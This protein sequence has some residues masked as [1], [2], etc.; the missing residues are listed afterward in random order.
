MG[1]RGRNNI[2]ELTV[3]QKG[4]QRPAPPV[5]LTKEE[6]A[7]WREVVS[8]LSPDWF[9]PDT[10]PLLVQYCRHVN[11]A[12]QISQLVETMMTGKKPRFMGRGAARDRVLWEK[13]LFLL[14]EKEESISRVIATLATK[15]RIC[16]QSTYDKSKKKGKRSGASL[17]D[18]TALGN[19]GSE[20]EEA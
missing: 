1:Q 10:F 8:G 15:M 2:I 18:P 6:A 14:L 9:T 5:E 3:A 12:R 13:H 11:R 20:G 17:W 19:E 16:Q 4:K 7:T